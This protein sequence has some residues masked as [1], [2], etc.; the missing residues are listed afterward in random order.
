MLSRDPTFLGKIAAVSGSAITVHLSQS[1]ASGLSFIN[2][3]IYK[4]GQV[5]SFVRV[6]QGYQDLFGVVSEVGA[7][8]LSD[9]AASVDDTGRW[10]SVEL[11][12]EVV[13]GSFDRGV[14]QYPNIGDAV[15]LAID[16]DLRRIYDAGGERHVEIGSLS[17]TDNIPAKIALDELVT[18]HSA[19]LGSTGSGKSTTIASL[20][21]AITASDREGGTY[22]SARIV[23]LVNGHRKYDTSGRRKW[24]TFR[25][26]PRRERSD[27][28][29]TFREDLVGAHHRVPP[30]S[31]RSAETAREAV[32]WM[33]L[34]SSRWRRIR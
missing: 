31:E 10:M 22:P 33:A 29:G 17:S 32:G 13:G 25:N 14:S 15:H 7:D 27:R 18:R 23:L 19:V 20:L 30:C 6:P 12:G 16:E 2:G 9:R 4:I 5:G 24:D 28:S 21:R 26:A 34:E 3:Q 8:A 11:V 1:V